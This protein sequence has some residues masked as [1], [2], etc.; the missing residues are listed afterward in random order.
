MVNRLA[1]CNSAIQQVENLRYGNTVHGAS[2]AR[3]LD[4]IDQGRVL[5][6]RT[7]LG[8]A[9]GPDVGR[10]ARKKSLRPCASA[11]L[12]LPACRVMLN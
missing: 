12:T 8:T 6:D 1:E 9:P 2:C 3:R 11:R 10:R 4:G 7:V 5:A